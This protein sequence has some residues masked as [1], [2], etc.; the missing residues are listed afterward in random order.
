MPI[1]KGKRLAK[2]GRRYLQHIHEEKESILGIH[3][4]FLLIDTTNNQTRKRA[5]DLN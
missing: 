2:I 1:N 3:V 4:E 5:K